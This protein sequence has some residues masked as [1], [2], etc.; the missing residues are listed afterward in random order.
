M[1][2]QPAYIEAYKR[3]DLERKI[4]QAFNALH[5]C[6]L[7]PRQCKVDRSSRQRGICKTGIQAKVASY[8]P[9]FGEE[10]VLV[11]S[12]GSG[13]IFFSNCNLMCNFCQNF[14][15]SHSGQ[16]EEVTDTQL[17]NMMIW[18]QNYGC[19]N[20]NLVTPSHIVP[21][22]LS[23]LKISIENGLSIPLVYN[24]SSYDSVFTIKLLD[25][26]IDIYMPDFKFMDP[27]QSELN[28]N[29]SDYPEIAKRAILEMY[30]QVGDL[31]V[32][33]KGIAQRGLIVRHL[34]MPGNTNGAKEIFEFIS[35]SVSRNTFTN[36]LKQYQPLGTAS[37]IPQINKRITDIEF[38]QSLELARLSGLHRIIY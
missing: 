33:S 3:G 14:D 23:A 26:I 27:I 31:V 37:Q 2:F 29:A 30:R 38:N 15:I 18:L 1:D 10:K 34:L 11:G 17:A 13:T 5:S 19:H 7:C 9:H 24:T 36:I 25:G 35:N 12:G 6:T 21:Q 28:M 32:D 20:I 22:I 16:G 8:Q 4:E